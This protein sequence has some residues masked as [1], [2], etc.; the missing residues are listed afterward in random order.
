MEI[1]ILYYIALLLHALKR[2]LEKK[3]KRSCS[4]T[5]HNS[6]RNNNNNNNNASHILENKRSFSNVLIKQI[7]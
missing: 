6:K 2:E 4:S 1:R 7:N 3:N 5:E